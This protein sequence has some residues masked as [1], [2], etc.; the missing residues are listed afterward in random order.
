MQRQCRVSVCGL[1]S[2]TAAGDLPR[3]SPARCIPNS[4]TREKP[5]QFSPLGRP[6]LSQADWRD[7]RKADTCNWLQT[8]W[9]KRP[10]QSPAGRLLP[11]AQS[12]CRQIFGLL[13]KVGLPPLGG[14]VLCLG[15]L[16]VGGYLAGHAAEADLLASTAQFRSAGRN[17]ST[18]PLPFFNGRP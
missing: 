17:Q 4:R 14:I 8:V 1:R 7:V 13:P 15:F 2:N 16:V 11:L 12:S 5:A 18:F 3:V 6:N 9:L 10:C